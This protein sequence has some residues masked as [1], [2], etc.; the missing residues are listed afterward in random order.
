MASVNAAASDS[1]V[2]VFIGGIDES[3]ESES[4]DR[5]QISWSAAQT[6][7]IN[8]LAT[9]KKPMAVIQMGGEYLTLHAFESFTI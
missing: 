6:S 7:I 2:I 5:E 3:I 4:R 8:T 1:D 9:Y